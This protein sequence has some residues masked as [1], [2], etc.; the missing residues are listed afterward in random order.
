MQYTL[1]FDHTKYEFVNLEGFK[2][3]QGFEYNTAQA[4]S[5]GNIAMLW[6]D[7]DAVEKTLEDGTELFTLVLRSTVYSKPSTDLKLSLT[8][9]ITDIEAWDKDLSLHNI[10]LTKQQTINDKP[11][12]LNESFS[13]SPNPTN[14]EVAFNI[15]SKLNKII[16]LDVSNAEG[17]IL[18]TQNFEVTKGD[19]IFHMNLRK[20]QYLLSGLYF[21]K[22]NGFTKRLIIK[23]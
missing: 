9:D 15:V 7:K 13:V 21:L 22:A 4:N 6:T 14:G 17:R 18:Y 20:N 12:T 1:H 8:N 16:R 19:N 5:T 11:Q 23:P 10:L 2:N 3:L